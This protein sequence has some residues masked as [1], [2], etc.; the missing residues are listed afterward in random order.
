VNAFLK[1]SNLSAEA[2][3]RVEQTL[4]DIHSVLPG[5]VSGMYITGSMAHSDYQPGKSDLDIT[6]LLE[7]WPSNEQI[8]VLRTLIRQK[9]AWMKRPE[10][11]FIFLELNALEGMLQG[12]VRALITERGR[13]HEKPF[14]MGPVLYHELKTQ[15]V[16][17]T[18]LPPAMLPGHIRPHQLKAFLLHNVNSYWQKWLDQHQGITIGL[19]LLFLFPRLTE[20][21]V[22]GL[23]RIHYTR[24]TGDIISKSGAGEFALHHLP[25][26]HRD[27]I[28]LALRIRM[29]RPVIP[30]PGP[31]VVK[32]SI[33][34][35]RQT[36]HFVRFM[37][38][39]M[40]ESST[41]PCSDENNPA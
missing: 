35:T 9:N 22:L 5:F 18:G 15:R 39:L 41:Q 29:E 4:S 38:A 37:I 17:I 8:R 6:V 30:F 34:R 1:T 27:I 11:S 13:L 10:L 28:Q 23:S 31:Y 25:E 21:S 12:P 20:W 36:L 32:P 40:N 3:P 7:H 19:L 16:H 14:D 24:C 26:H 33:R 2:G